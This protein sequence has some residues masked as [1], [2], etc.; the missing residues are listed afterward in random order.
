MSA[1][2][3][4]AMLGEIL[5]QCVTTR[6][7]CYALAS[8]PASACC[9]P[10]QGDERDRSA[11]QRAARQLSGRMGRKAGRKH[12][13]I[14][15]VE[16]VDCAGG[17]HTEQGHAH[18]HC[19]IHKASGSRAARKVKRAGSGTDYRQAYLSCEPV[20]AREGF[21]RRSN[22]GKIG[23]GPMWLLCPGSSP[24]R[25]VAVLRISRS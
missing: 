20:I 23:S 17:E 19:E 21:P 16:E 24:Q 22:R 2:S 25:V 1:P 13:A 15:L 4:R 14:E 8:H 11:S 6:N 7:G 3:V 5:M 18:C 10:A 12:S 9:E